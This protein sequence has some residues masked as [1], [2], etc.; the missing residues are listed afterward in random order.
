[1]IRSETRR[2]TAVINENPTMQDVLRQFYPK[3]LESY[4]PAAN[5]AKAVHHIS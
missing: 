4:T 3:Y 1:M 2:M 5:Q